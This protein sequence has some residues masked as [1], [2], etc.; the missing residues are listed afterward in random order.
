MRKTQSASPKHP[1][2]IL[3]HEVLPA[4]KLSISQAARDLA[5]TRQVLHHILAGTASVTPNIALRLERLCVVMVG[6]ANRD[7]RLL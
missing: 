3:R 1:G 5:I 7:L 6:Q 2:A 4:L